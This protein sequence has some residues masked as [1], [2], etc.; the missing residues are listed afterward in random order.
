MLPGLTTSTYFS[1]NGITRNWVYDFAIQNESEVQ[2]WLTSPAGVI[3]QVTTSYSINTVTSTVTYPTIGS[4]LTPV[5]TGWGLELRRVLPL[6]QAT[7]LV[8][9]GSLDSEVLESALDKLT[10]IAQQIKAGSPSGYSGGSGA[11]GFSGSGTS[12]FSG[13]NGT[14]GTNG[15]SGT[16]GTSGISG[17]G[18]SGASG[19]SG[20]SGI[21]ATGVSGTSGT[22]GFAGA[23]AAGGKTPNSYVEIVGPHI[24]TST[25][26]EDIPGLTTTITLDEAVELVALLTADLYLESG[27]NIT[28]HLAINI[29]GVDH[30]DTVLIY[31]RRELSL[32][33]C[34]IEPES[35][36]LEFIRL[37]GVGADRI[38]R[39]S[40]ELL[41]R[42][43]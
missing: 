35:L 8:N 27:P 28:A 30:Q 2:I 33:P 31:G 1:G 20:L 17:A 15:T 21:N 36:R 39:E 34:S 13:I 42:I 37:K 29:D 3:S 9:Q 23:S 40:R 16:S 22:S 18:T 7:D 5:A 4:A 10:M 38:I 12:G 25:I 14:N 41:L 24:V 32:L 6:T 11:S 26:L 43:S 19:T